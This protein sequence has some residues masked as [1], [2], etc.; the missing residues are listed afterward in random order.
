LDQPDSTNSPGNKNGGIVGR[1]LAKNFGWRIH[2]FAGCWRVADFSAARKLSAQGLWRLAAFFPAP[3]TVIAPL[4]NAWNVFKILQDTRAPWFP[5]IPS[6]VKGVI[7]FHLIASA[8]LTV[9]W[10]FV[11]VG[12]V[13]K[14]RWYPNG[15]A[16]LCAASL[17]RSA[18]QP[19]V[20]TQQWLALFFPCLIWTV[21]L[22]KSRRA[23][24]TFVGVRAGDVARVF[25]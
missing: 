6:I 8:A 3:T 2:E 16:I 21:Y 9:G 17:V 11:L 25:D 4:L 7:L 23:K 24:N 10:S 1:R 19:G 5:T 18:L 15:F 14:K 20:T 22:F 13:R 12:M